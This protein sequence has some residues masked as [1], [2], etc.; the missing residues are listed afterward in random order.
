MV[1]AIERV[2]EGILLFILVFFLL[3]PVVVVD[4]IIKLLIVIHLVLFVDLTDLGIKGNHLPVEQI[5]F[6]LTR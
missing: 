2:L 4:S 3:L 6:D 5:I 1:L